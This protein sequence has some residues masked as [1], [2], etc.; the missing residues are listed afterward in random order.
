[1]RERRR[2][3]AL[4]QAARE[5]GVMASSNVYVQQI[6]A[7]RRAIACTHP[8]PFPWTCATHVTKTK[9]QLSVFIYI[10]QNEFVRIFSISARQV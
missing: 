8:C 7:G 5:R 9:V 6:E 10:I 4:Q 3:A 1:M 2:G